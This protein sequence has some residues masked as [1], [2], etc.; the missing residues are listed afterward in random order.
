MSIILPPNLQP[1]ATGIAFFQADDSSGAHTG[2]MGT[3]AQIDAAYVAW[4]A[5]HPSPPVVV[6]I[7]IISIPTSNPGI[8][9]ALHIVNNT[10][11][12]SQGPS[13][14]AVQIGT[15]GPTGGVA[16]I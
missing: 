14:A 3:Q 12:V 6:P 9:G 5:I 15:T 11:Y 7:S 13:A 16:V 8:T 10:L 4:I 1:G 2:C